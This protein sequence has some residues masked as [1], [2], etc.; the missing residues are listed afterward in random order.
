MTEP[1]TNTGYLSDHWTDDDHF[2]SDYRPA[3]LDIVTSAQTP[4]TVGIFGPW[5]SGKTSLLRML[6]KDI[7]DKGTQPLRTVWFTAWKYDRHEA[8]W[9]ALILRV[10]DALYPKVEEKDRT[11][12]QQQQVILLDQLQESVYQD[13]NWQELGQLTVNWWQFLRGGGKAGAEIAAAFIPGAGLF[14]QM[15]EVMGGDKQADAEMTE[16]AKAIRREIKNF[17]RAQLTSMEQFESAFKEALSAT[18]GE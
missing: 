6:E 3:L 17:Q 11:P 14:K 12:E 5:G 10:L 15:V 7:A 9:R 18:L 13:V 16:A 2:F 4:L 1:W 8:L